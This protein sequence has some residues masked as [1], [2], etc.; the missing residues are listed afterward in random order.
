M[1]CLETLPNVV[2]FPDPSTLHPLPWAGGD[3]FR[4]AEILGTTSVS[5]NGMSNLHY[6][7]R[8]ALIKLFKRLEV[9][10]IS[11]LTGTEIGFRMLQRSSREP[12]FSEPDYC[13]QLSF[14]SQEDILFYIESELHASGI[15]I[16][17]MH[18]EGAPGMFEFTMKPAEGIKA[19]D[20]MFLFKSY[21]KELA[22][23]KDHTVSFVTKMT[24]YELGNTLHLNISL[25]NKQGKNILYDNSHEHQ[26]SDTARHW[27]AGLVKHAGAL[28]A[29]CVP[30][31]N[32]YRRVGKF[33]EPSVADW[34]L[35]NRF[36]SFRVKNSGE[37][38][39]Y[40]ENRLPSALANPY[41]AMAATLAAGLDG[42]ENRLQCP[43][44]E[45]KEAKPIPANLSEALIALEKDEFMKKSLGEDMISAFI[46]IK[47]ECELA[48]FISHDVNMDNEAEI[49]AERLFYER[50]L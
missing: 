9:E 7:S 21:I 38:G 6:N 31:V 28:T 13:S 43:P 11:V 44:M 41:L 15:D 20:S 40:I 47:K 19:L 12:P 17:T 10:G 33:L 50:L 30:T 34:S 37:S 29:L 27:I 3:D 39:T 24:S 25:W 45:D 5:P 14:S 42:I 36:V 4:V 1:P 48:K 23:R 46:D 22:K 8:D 26:L 18:T 49:I 16:E 35:D 2:F 32:C